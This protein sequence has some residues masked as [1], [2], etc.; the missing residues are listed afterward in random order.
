MCV[1]HV[2]C[3]HALGRASCQAVTILFLLGTV[4]LWE[5]SLEN[6]VG[7]VMLERV[8]SS[9]EGLQTLAIQTRCP[10]HPQILH[11]HHLISF[12]SVRLETR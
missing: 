5:A 8:V 9:D 2:R 6:N 12:Q 7:Q 3:K 10:V 1:S 11:V 4:K